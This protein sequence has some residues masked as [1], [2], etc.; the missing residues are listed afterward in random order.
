MSTRTVDHAPATPTDVE[1]ATP[2]S[3][4]GRCAAERRVR[5]TPPAPAATTSV[6]PLDVDTLADIVV[7]LGRAEDLWRPHVRHDPLSRTSVRLVATDRYDVW[8]LGWTP[9][10]QVDP[11]DHGG[12]AAA[13]VVLDGTLTEVT[14]GVAGTTTATLRAGAV[15]TVR[16]GTVHD[17]VALHDHPATSLYVY[18]PPLST[19]TF[20]EADGTPRHTEEVEPVPAILDAT[21]TA[22]ALHPSGSNR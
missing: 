18:S 17:V 10:Q 22:R 3:A 4:A 2:P 9:G 1:P 13:F 12:A 8:L 21:G 20:Y 5:L 15:S 11:H 7:G 16:P 14:I 6:T 19:M